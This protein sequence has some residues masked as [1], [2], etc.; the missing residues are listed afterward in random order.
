MVPPGFTKLAVWIDPD[1]D[2]DLDLYLVNHVP[3]EAPTQLL[4]NDGTGRF[5]AAPELGLDLEMQGM[6][7]DS[8]DLNG[9][10]APEY[11]LAGLQEIAILESQPGGW[12]RIDLAAGVR[13]SEDPTRWSAW[14]SAWVDLDNDGVVELHA[15]FG[16]RDGDH[17]GE[18]VLQPDA[19][20]RRGADAQFVQVAEAWGLAQDANDRAVAF[21]DLDR[22]GWLDAIKRAERGPA[23]LHRARCG[24]E[25]WLQVDLRGPAGN[26]HG[27]GASVTVEAEGLRAQTRWITA[28]GPGY[29]A[30]QP[31]EAHF[32]L[33]GNA[34]AQRLVVSWPD[35]ARSVFTSV[36]G[37]QS[38]TVL[39]PDG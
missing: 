4:L 9:D 23:T 33:G 17:P 30:N 18:P 38:V 11:A 5:T 12:A 3:L 6:G 14:S 26:P 28:Q 37:S 19:L 15:G 29:L 22:D 21:V 2:G 32:G 7:F 1:R 10:G 20:Y 39:Y 34:V 36:A 25:G 24:E 31:P 27:I 13:P 8:A 35:G 16:P